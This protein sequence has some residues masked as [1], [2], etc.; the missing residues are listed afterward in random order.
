VEEKTAET[1]KKAERGELK[2]TL[3]CFMLQLRDVEVLELSFFGQKAIRG[4]NGGIN[5]TTRQMIPSF[6]A[7]G[8]TEILKPLAEAH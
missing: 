7:T 2:S 3:P 8:V 4:A 5:S 6:E 1:E